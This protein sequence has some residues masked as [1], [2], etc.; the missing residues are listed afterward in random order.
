[1]LKALL[2]RYLPARVKSTIRNLQRLLRIIIFSI[3]R[4]LDLSLTFLLSP[5]WIG[6]FFKPWRSNTIMVYG[7]SDRRKGDNDSVETNTLFQSI[8]NSRFSDAVFIYR[9]NK[10]KLPT[11][12]F[13]WK[14]S[15]IQPKI[16]IFSSYDKHAPKQPALLVV[17]LLKFKGCKVVS[18]WWDTCS[19][20]F[21]KKNDPELR[22]F[23]LNVILDNPEKMFL[24]EIEQT[25]KGQVLFAHPPVWFE[26]KV[27]DISQRT[28]DFFFCG[29][30]SSYRSHRKKLMEVF[31]HQNIKHEIFT[32]GEIN[33]S[34]ADYINKIRSSK[35]G[36]SLPE[37]VDCDQL[38]ARVL[39]VTL[40]GTLLIDRKN[41]Q[42][43]KLFEDG[44][45]YL[46]FTDS[47][48]LQEL[49]EKILANPSQYSHI[50]KQGHIRAKSLC[51]PDSFWDQILL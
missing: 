31:R 48:E 28:T 2:A 7:N 39:E 8:A 6:G 37:S 49:I 46:S 12:E 13:L 11:L 18:L 21:L 32:S 5:F 25:L 10:C 1:M 44:S 35:I 38:K 34:Y 42:T 26:G 45:E 3:F 24:E 30:M 15:K 16:T 27:I 14:A 43:D 9:H 20:H 4:I 41:S 22:L 51:D 23:D 19:Q 33:L 40:S 47:T 50:A 36:L 17:R 29:S